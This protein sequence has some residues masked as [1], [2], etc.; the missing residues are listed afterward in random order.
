MRNLA[1]KIICILYLSVLF[2]GCGNGEPPKTNSEVVFAASIPPVAMILKE[3][4]KGRADVIIVLPS[5][6]SP[7]SFEPKPSD[8]AEVSG[9]VAL[10]YVGAGIDQWATE[11]QN[12]NLINLVEMVPDWLIIHTGD[13][14]AGGNIDGHFWL[15]PTAV[16]EILS[17]LTER[18][19]DVDPGGKEIYTANKLEFERKLHSLIGRHATNNDRL[20]K[21]IQTHAASSYLFRADN[22]LGYKTV[23]VIYPVH[24]AEPSAAHIVDLIN[25]IYTEHVDL[26][27]AEKQMRRDIADSLSSETGVP[28]VELDPLGGGT[29]Y[30]DFIQNNLNAIE[31]ALEMSDSNE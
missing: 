20:I 2:T 11:F 31:Q 24:G 8:V 12:E 26:I 28:V 7:H 16:M 19:S 9:T 30:I 6:A 22:R 21:V 15:D 25:I 17:P 5:G 23:G 3:L 1:V 13:E 4:V 14:H 29:A 27:I 10:F 18:L